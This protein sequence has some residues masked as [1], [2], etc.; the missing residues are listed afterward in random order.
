MTVSPGD[1]KD[2]ARALREND[3]SELDFLY[4]MTGVDYGEELG[5]VYHLRST[6]LHRIHWCLKTRTADRE[7][8]EIDTV[9]DIWKSG[10]IS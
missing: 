6:T 5:V 3:D 4:C 9:S 2:L 10:R 7:N 8:P 1:L